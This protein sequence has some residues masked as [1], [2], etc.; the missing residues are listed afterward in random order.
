M[1]QTSCQVS[2]DKNPTKTT[3]PEIPPVILESENN[4]EDIS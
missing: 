3:K 2:T 4:L 1:G